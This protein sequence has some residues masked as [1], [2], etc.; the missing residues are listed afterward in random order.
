MSAERSAEFFSEKDPLSIYD[1]PLGEVPA[2]PIGSYSHVDGNGNKKSAVEVAEVK[3]V[4]SI[5][6][7]EMTDT[8]NGEHNSIVIKHRAW[9]WVGGALATAMG[10]TAAGVGTAFAI[11]H[12]RRKNRRTSTE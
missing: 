8:P 11:E 1:N 6:G 5:V 7:A 12:H 2:V 3:N 9:I 4:A 10:L